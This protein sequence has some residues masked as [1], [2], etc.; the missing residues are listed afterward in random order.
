VAIEVLRQFG[1]AITVGPTPPATPAAGWVHVDTSRVVGTYVADV[2]VVPA[3]FGQ[4]DVTVTDTNVTADSLV[5]ASLA[6]NADWDADELEDLVVV[7]TALAGS[8]VFTITGPGQS[9]LGG[10]FRIVYQ[11][12]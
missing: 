12:G 3:T 8:V 11:I 10:L 1:T 7:P 9:P 2:S 6:P 5:I 4:V